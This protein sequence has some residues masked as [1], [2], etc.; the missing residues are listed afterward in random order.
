MSIRWSL[1]IST[2]RIEGSSF[3]SEV[4]RHAEPPLQKWRSPEARCCR[5]FSS[6]SLLLIQRIGLPAILDTSFYEELQMI[7]VK[8][9]QLP[10]ASLPTSRRGILTAPSGAEK[11]AL[12]IYRTARGRRLGRERI[13]K[14]M[15]DID[16][17]S[18]RSALAKGVSVLEVITKFVTEVDGRS[19][20]MLQKRVAGPVKA[21]I[22]IDPFLQGHCRQR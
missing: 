10:K 15:M 17:E 22:P 20:E 18:A 11:V 5:G 4:G 9:G 6:R 2:R 14:Y 12:R 7:V 21:A 16:P 1:Q 8:I 3:V 19:A 13:G